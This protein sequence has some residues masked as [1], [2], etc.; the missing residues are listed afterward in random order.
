MSDPLLLREDRGSIAILTLNRPEKRNALSQALIAQL[1]DQLD[2]LKVDSAIRVVILTGNGPTFCAGLDL[3]E[4]YGSG[5]DTKSEGRAVTEVQ[6][7]ADLLDAAHKL[8]KPTIAALNGDAL[9]GGAG[10]A[11]GCDFVLM[12]P[13]ARLGYPEALR[14]LAPAM[15]MHDLIRLVGQR[16]ARHLLLTAKPLDATTC[17]SWGLANAV[18]QPDSLLADAIALAGDLCKCGPKALATIKELF[19]EASAR[20]RSLRGAAAITAAIR[21]SDEAMEGM[22]AFLEKRGPRWTAPN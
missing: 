8:P 4:A 2:R 10:L 7:L 18:S 13:T 15:V 12:S 9:A 21:I 1:S 3:K 6:A 19:D 20:P 5:T 22:H 16:R 11:M 14:G 17:V